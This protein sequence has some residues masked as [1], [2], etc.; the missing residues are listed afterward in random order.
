MTLDARAFKGLSRF[1]APSAG[2]PMADRALSEGLIS[3]GQLQECIAE[4]D[5]SGRPLDEILVER[6]FLKADEA[7]RLRNPAIPPEVLQAAQDP[8][9]LAGHYVLVAR[10]GAGGMAEVWKAWDRSLGRWVALKHLKA[11]VGHPTQRIEREGRMAGQ[12]SHPAII[13]IFERGI[14]DGR[15]FLVMP[16]VDGQPPKPPLPWREA[17]RLAVD[18]AG[19]LAHAHASGVLHR[20]VKPS[21]I[22]LDQGGRVLLADFGLAIPSNSG[23]SR[24]AVSGTPE[25]A[26]PEQVRG[27]V[28]DART[29]IYSLGATLYH[30]VSGR[31]PFTG[32]DPTEIGERV[33]NGPPPP[34]DGVPRGLARIIRKAMERDRDL[35]YADVAELARD[36]RVYLDLHAASPRVSAK[37]F[38]AILG[39]ALMPWAASWILLE[40]SRSRERTLNAMSL[41]EEGRR[42]LEAAE[43]LRVQLGPESPAVVE[44]AS[45]ARV[46]FE[47]AASG[48][49]AALPEAEAGLGRCLEL[50]GRDADAQA[51]FSRAGSLPDAQVGLARA[52]FRRW[53]NGDGR[54]SAAL[55]FL[56]RAQGARPSPSLD[57]YRALALDRGAEALALAT[58]PT[59]D[60]AADE[61]LLL[62]LGTAALDLGRAD[63]AL[64]L[65]ARAERLRPGDPATLFH[66]AR[67]LRARGDRVG[68]ESVLVEA[69]RRAPVAWGLRPQAV[70]MLESV[71][72][73]GGDRP[74]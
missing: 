70:E 14:H 49:G 65:I 17:V 24:W 61:V 33:L 42:A 52:A 53:L 28:L 3:P 66:R 71:R 10:I 48:V 73:A 60:Q 43:S 7:L 64:A 35:R 5:R 1:L 51:C 40:Q 72:S 62:A 63:P 67:A 30:F 32:R 69:L 13:S 34:L 31:P 45:R 46:L 74:R 47:K 4:Q 36:L 56:D 37:V 16:F 18:I 22:L 8:G 41:Q 57:A 2:G 19:A 55:P 27:D 20:D 29:D 39:L 25:Y 54:A 44:A 6:G 12:L 26:S 15:P 23:A 11:E 68:V 50:A 9:R 59:P 58:P 38:L 21:N